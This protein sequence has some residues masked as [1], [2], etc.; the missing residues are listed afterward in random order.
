MITLTYKQIRHP[1]FN[2][3]L[4]KIARAKMSYQSA[5]RIVSIIKD[6]AKEQAESD[7]VFNTLKDK[8]FEVDPT[9]EKML[10][11]KEDTKDEAIKQLEEFDNTKVEIQKARITPQELFHVE[12]SPSEV[13]L[14][15]GLLED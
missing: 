8:F 2:Q 4:N 3:L 15:E 13:M 6:I 5:K 10:R 1:D 7:E 9:N 12:L 11:Y 14:L